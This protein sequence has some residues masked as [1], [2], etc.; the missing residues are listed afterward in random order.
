MC[1]HSVLPALALRV[2][3]LLIS[4]MLWCE[5]IAVLMS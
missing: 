4:D 1:F 3:A 2:F 5:H